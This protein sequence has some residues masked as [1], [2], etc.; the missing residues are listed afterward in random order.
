MANSSPLDRF[1]GT[2]DELLALGT[3]VQ[4]VL[5]E[6]I[7]ALHHPGA[8]VYQR[9]VARHLDIERKRA[10]I[11]ATCLLR[12]AT[13]QI[14]PAETRC[15]AAALEIAAELERIAYLVRDLAR[16]P[17]TGVPEFSAQAGDLVPMVEE[18]LALL[19]QA[20]QAL[21][22]GDQALARQ[23]PQPADRINRAYTYLYRRFAESQDR[24]TVLKPAQLRLLLRMVQ[25]HRQIANRIDSVCAWVL[26]AL[27]EPD[28]EITKEGLR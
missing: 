19:D 14:S 7:S 25:D 18:A 12:I 8:V 23:R 9:L 20:L 24:A 17:L 1:A 11:E 4:E 10:E 15:L 28:Q 13:R 16:A 26:F 27:T 2:K 22:L 5:T 3:L 21:A 6:S